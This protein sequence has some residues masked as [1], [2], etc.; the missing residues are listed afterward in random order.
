M[1]EENINEFK[2]DNICYSSVNSKNERKQI[3]QDISGYAY[4]G[5]VFAVLGPSGAGK[6]SLLSVL[7]L[8]CS[9][10]NM[11]I[12]GRCAL[13]GQQLNK[14]MFQDYFYLVP[15]DDSHRAFIT[16]RETLRFAA[17]FYINDNDE[18]KDKV[19]EDLLVKLGLENCKN[20]R[21]GNQFLQG[22]S[23]GQKKDYPSV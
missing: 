1:S 11:I 6:T 10:K 22:L 16:C 4:S 17:D 19:V 20:T 9:G 14:T 5:E 21:V 2:F 18:V 12:E 3:L 7:S 15:Q 13:N 8:N 23:G